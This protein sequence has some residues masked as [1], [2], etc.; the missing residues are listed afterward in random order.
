VN[1]EAPDPAFEDALRAI[2]GDDAA[3]RRAI[4]ILRDE[5]KTAVGFERTILIALIGLPERE[6]GDPSK[7]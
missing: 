2:V 7:P 5:L 6:A 4:Q 3:S 1:D